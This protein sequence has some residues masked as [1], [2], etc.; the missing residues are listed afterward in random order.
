MRKQL[1]SMWTISSFHI[2]AKPET[3]HFK[4]VYL[5][6]MTGISAS[7]K[8]TVKSV[9]FLWKLKDVGFLNKQTKKTI[10]SNNKQSFQCPNLFLCRLETLKGGSKTC[11]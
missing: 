1:S 6:C 4:Q 2:Q 7:L 5:G 11:F 3:G 10:E 9:D 8:G